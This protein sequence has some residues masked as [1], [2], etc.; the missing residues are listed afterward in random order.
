MISCTNKGNVADIQGAASLKWL[1]LDHLYSCF[2]I[3][4]FDRGSQGKSAMSMNP[5]ERNTVDGQGKCV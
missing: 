3:E 2:L 4:S 1:L 5:T